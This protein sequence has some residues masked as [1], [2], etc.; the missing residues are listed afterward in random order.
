MLCFAG[1]SKKLAEVTGILISNLDVKG[2]VIYCCKKPKL[3]LISVT[4]VF[5]A[6]LFVSL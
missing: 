4:G 3:T 1:V 5:A 2:L 6:V